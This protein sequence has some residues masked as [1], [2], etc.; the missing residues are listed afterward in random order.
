MAPEASWDA[1][2]AQTFNKELHFQGVS[3]EPTKKKI[4]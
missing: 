1:T 3:I 4:L 2:E